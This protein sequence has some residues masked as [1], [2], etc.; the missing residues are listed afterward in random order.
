MLAV[1]TTK[2]SHDVYLRGKDGEYHFWFTMDDAYGWPFLAANRTAGGD[3]VY[4]VGGIVP[5]AI[6]AVI[7]VFGLVAILRWTKSLISTG[8]RPPR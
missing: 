3:I 7:F 4:R 6:M 2:R 5:N 8:D 1:N